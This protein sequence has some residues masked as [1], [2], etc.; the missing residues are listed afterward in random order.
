[1]SIK[2][3]CCSNLSAVRE[4]NVLKAIARLNTDFNNAFATLTASI[5]D[6]R[7]E[8]GTMN[9]EMGAMNTTVRGLRTEMETIR[10]EMETMRTE[11]GMIST[12]M[13]T[14]RI[15]M[16]T[17]N[18]YVREAMQDMRASMEDFDYNAR[19]RTLN[20]TA[21]R[22]EYILHRLRNTTT[23]KLVD[24][25]QTLGEV[26]ALLVGEVNRY[27]EALGQTPTGSVEEKKA[28]LL[29]FIGVRSY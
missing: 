19:A 2:V 3:D 28:Q 25:P 11:M 29:Q 20:S 10:T 27:L 18:T 22:S 7:T 6:L 23:H 4:D 24:L 14:M 17:M 5:T 16:G 1:M 9:P 8:M 21:N 26:K 15:E 13:G 12:E